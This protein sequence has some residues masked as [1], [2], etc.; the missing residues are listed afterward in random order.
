MKRKAIDNRHAGHNWQFIL[1]Q[2]W[3]NDKKKKTNRFLPFFVLLCYLVCISFVHLMIPNCYINSV[4]ILLATFLF[5]C[6]RFELPAT[7]NWKRFKYLMLFKRFYSVFS[8]IIW[9]LSNTDYAIFNAALNATL[10]LRAVW[11]MA[12]SVSKNEPRKKYRQ[13]CHTLES[14]HEGIVPPHLVFFYQ[15]VSELR[16][17]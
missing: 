10:N 1:A 17:F 11:M 16:S 13:I 9:V 7:E 15:N 5:E 4:L 14:D 3:H 8:S 12:S 6:F 2:I